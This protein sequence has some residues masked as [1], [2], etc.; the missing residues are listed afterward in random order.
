MTENDLDAGREAGGVLTFIIIAALAS[1]VTGA[2]L[3]ARL[4]D[5]IGADPDG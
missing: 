4:G 2:L 3:G 5:V 1:L